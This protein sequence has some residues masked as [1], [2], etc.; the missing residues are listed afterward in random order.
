[1]ISEEK[2]KIF[3][4]ID[5]FLNVLEEKER[6]KVPKKLRE[7]YKREKLEGYNP[8]YDLRRPIQ[9]QNMKRETI[10]MIGLL[11]LNYWCEN[12]EEKN[13]LREIFRKNEQKYQEELREK[14]N[15]NDL[16][17]KRKKRNSNDI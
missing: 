3:S 7:M 13:K 4:E 14:Y 11:H 15:T 8:Q 5:A 12:E 2:R 17:K 1:M 9:E 6:N 16:F 10:A